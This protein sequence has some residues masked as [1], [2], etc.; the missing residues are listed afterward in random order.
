[1]VFKH[2]IPNLQYAAGAVLVLV[3]FFAV[4]VATLSEVE[5]SA[6]YADREIIPQDEDISR[7]IERSSPNDS[8]EQEEPSTLSL[9]R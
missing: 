7:T 6:I 4:N 3:G 2:I 1:M 5:N 8:N 9:S